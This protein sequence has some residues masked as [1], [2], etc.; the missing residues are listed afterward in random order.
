MKIDKLLDPPIIENHLHK[1]FSSQNIK[2]TLKGE[3]KYLTILLDYSLFGSLSLMKIF[4][5]QKEYNNPWIPE[6]TNEVLGI[7]ILEGI[8]KIILD[9]SENVYEIGNKYNLTKNYSILPIKDTIFLL[10]KQK[11]S[12]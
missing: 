7:Q 1:I 6:H 11:I 12:K 5:D 10:V 2:K 8:G 9:E 4:S 3:K